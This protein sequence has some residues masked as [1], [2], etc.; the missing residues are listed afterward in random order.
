[1]ACFWF[2]SYSTRARCKHNTGEAAAA[3]SAGIFPGD[4]V[5]TSEFKSSMQEAKVKAATA[6]F[7]T[8]KMQEC[9]ATD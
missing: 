3:M 7:I 4:P 8:G 5:Y 2:P 6:G 1:M 9:E